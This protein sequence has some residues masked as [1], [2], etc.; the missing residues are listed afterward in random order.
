MS[1]PGT[2]SWLKEIDNARPSSPGPDAPDHD[3]KGSQQPLES[4]RQ[5]ATAAEDGSVLKAPKLVFP[6]GP[7]AVAPSVDV[8]TYWDP[9]KS[10]PKPTRKSPVRFSLEKIQIPK[11]GKHS[12]MFPIVTPNGTETA[13]AEVPSV[14]GMQPSLHR[15]PDGKPKVRQ[16]DPNGV[17]QTVHPSK[18]KKFFGSDSPPTPNVSSRRRLL[19]DVPQSLNA[20]EALENDHLVPETF[21]SNLVTG[22]IGGIIILSGFALYRLQRYWCGKRRLADP[23]AESGDLDPHELV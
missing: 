5:D 21:S 7:V 16:V 12:N 6:A 2:P 9:D 1:T 22:A 19:N 11:V 18:A 17:P 23:E 14:D 8:T 4:P 3:A 13:V 20:S 10:V 15:Y